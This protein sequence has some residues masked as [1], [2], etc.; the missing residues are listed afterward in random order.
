MSCNCKNNQNQGADFVCLC[1]RFEFPP[2]LRIGAGLSQLPRQ[3]AGFPEF[4]R[5]ML[6]EL[7]QRPALATW[8]ARG[9]NDLGMMLFDMWA[10]V[11]DALSLYDKAISD[12]TYLRTAD[13][14]PSLRRLVALLGYRPLPAVAATVPLAALAEGRLS[15]TLPA[16]TAF[17]SA[18]FDGNP[19]QVFELNQDTVIHP[20]TN[21]WSVQRPARVNIGATNPSALLIN[22]QG[23][24]NAGDLLFLRDTGNTGQNQALQVSKIG[25]I[26]GDDER[27]Y[28]WVQ[29]S[30]SSS[31][32]GAT[33]I[34]QLQLQ[35]PRQSAALWT[36]TGTAVGTNTLTL[37][38]IYRQISTGDHILVQKGKGEARWYQV[39]DVADVERNPFATATIPI[40]VTQ[41]TLDVNID[42]NS[43][44]KTSDTWP[45]TIKKQLK[46]YF[47]MATA[48]TIVREPKVTLAAND[49][50]VLEE[51]QDVPIDGHNPESFLFSDK[52]LQ[53]RTAEGALNT[54]HT[55][56]SLFPGQSWTPE[57]KMPVT[58]FGNVIMAS[59]GESIRNEILGSGDASQ[60]NQTFQLKKKPLTYLF[61]PSG[62]N[63]QGIANT[64][65]VYVNNVLWRE[66]NT[67][68]G[69]G[70]EDEVYIVRQDDQ[71][72]TQVTFG[73]GIR[74]RRLPTGAGNVV[75]HYRYGAGAA[76]PPADS[77]TQISRPVNGLKSI[78]NPVPASGGS[79][80]EAPD[81]LR[82][83]AP[84]SALIL[85]RAI[86]IKD[87]EVVAL[88]VPGVIVVKSEWRWHE[89]QQRAVAF[90]WYRGEPGIGN[91]V[92][93]H[94]HQLTDPTTPLH[95]EEA[96]A[97]NFALE[98]SIQIDPRYV[99]TVVLANVR[100][101]LTD[102]DNGL[103][104]AKQ[105]SIEKPVF[106]S[107]IFEAVLSV[108]GTTAISGILWNGTAFNDY[109]IAPGNGKYFQ[110]APNGLTLKQ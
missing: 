5:A 72:E 78:K 76:S 89:S 37:D 57:L 13:L 7:R 27:S 3:L 43:R 103:L 16:G 36:V 100:Q 67:F 22:R 47:G 60:K 98:L 65:S 61:K 110:L 28:T 102:P 46:V 25:K 20:L 104:A 101:Y 54:G 59:R 109:A 105:L 52:N 41:L 68:F 48:G 92:A 95:V 9:E 44:R 50:M 2:V 77:I 4:R 97:M 45:D 21:Q 18:G 84:R 34:S 33:P 23:S 69:M 26:R 108:E 73:D 82:N 10:Y 31:L 15:V 91:K 81:S 42:D 64:L 94:V 75:A 39:D 32:S 38:N 12:E 53:S 17:R 40:L 58:A 93:Q 14:R 83:Y 62:A 79:D 51:P 55:A 8:E 80:A 24:I 90:I 99:N 66:V 70:P 29:F 49:P 87:M 56:I 19:P 106:R 1:D 107:Q 30:S 6:Y 85:G 11:C 71:Q 86:S 96:Q 35:A 63:D 88:S 74:G